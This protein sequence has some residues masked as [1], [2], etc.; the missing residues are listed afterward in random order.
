VSKTASNDTSVRAPNTGTPAE[1]GWINHTLDFL[2]QYFVITQRDAAITPLLSPEQ[3]WF[4]RKSIELQ[5]Q[6]ARMA[7]LNND[8]ALYKMSLAEAQAAISDSL[9][10]SSKEA[11]LKKLVELQ[12][13]TLRPGV[14]SLA[15]S[16]SS[17]QQLQAQVPAKT[18]S[19]Q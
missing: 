10:G 17:L 16:I 18:G 3:I 12:A 11:L 1:P 8:P 13:A 4:I 15:A 14:H 19:K 2:G 5:L 6:Q 7:A 9:Q